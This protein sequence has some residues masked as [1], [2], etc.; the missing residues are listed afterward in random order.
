[1]SVNIDVYLFDATGADLECALAALPEADR[2]RAKGIG[3]DQRRREFVFGRL[4]A[5]HALARCVGGRWVLRAAPN[6]RPVAV[7]DDGREHGAVNISHSR[8]LVACAASAEAA[9]APGCDIEA[10]RPRS[11]ASW[12]RIADGSVSHPMFDDGERQWLSAAAVDLRDDRL[13]ALWT[14]KEALG[15]ATGRG[16]YR[17]A[18]NSRHADV[19]ALTRAISGAGSAFH[20][21]PLDGGWHAYVMRLPAH[22]LTVAAPAACVVRRVD[23]AAS[24]LLRTPD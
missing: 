16:I 10:R 19:E 4:L 22:W 18:L 8:G 21:V 1:M 3:A 24:A 6:R 7:A 13:I 14:V 12:R 11:A 17:G 2:L 5:A 23:V 15:K 9:L 20:Q